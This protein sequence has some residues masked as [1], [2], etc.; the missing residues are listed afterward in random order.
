M[1]LEFIS[2]V[3]FL[4]NLFKT[5]LY[6][7]CLICR[8]CYFLY[9]KL[10]LSIG[11]LMATFSGFVSCLPWR[12]Y[13]WFVFWITA[14]MHT[15]TFLWPFVYYNIQLYCI[16][17][18]DCLSFWRYTFPIFHGYILIFV[19]LIVSCNYCMYEAR[20]TLHWLYSPD[21]ILPSAHWAELCHYLWVLC[22]V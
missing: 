22:L 16:Y 11:P 7:F 17:V 6:F 10:L 19:L 1:A 21:A 4:L 5:L 14:H 15:S 3:V 8:F 12:L 2:L 13:T 9:R 20:C 18:V